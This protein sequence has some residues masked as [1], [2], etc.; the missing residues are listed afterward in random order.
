MPTKQVENELERTNEEVAA[1]AREAARRMMSLQRSGAAR[2]VKAS[3]PLAKS[4]PA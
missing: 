4:D 3:A 2:V 1:P